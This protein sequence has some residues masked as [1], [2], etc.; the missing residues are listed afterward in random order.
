MFARLISTLIPNEKLDELIRVWRDLDTPEM[1]SIK[2]YREAYLLTNRETG[3]AISMT[4]WDSENDAITNQQNDYI[5]KQINKFYKGPISPDE[6][7]YRID[8]GQIAGFSIE[9]NTDDAHSHEISYNG[10]EYRFIDSL[11]DI[12]SLIL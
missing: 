1:K 12:I 9:Y 6:I 4:L 10:D 8:K 11:T 3:K 5:Q 2:G 7:K